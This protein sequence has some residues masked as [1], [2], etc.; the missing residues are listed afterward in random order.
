MISYVGQRFGHYI[1]VEIIDRGGF[2]DVYL[3]RHVYLQTYA[4][5]KVLK[6]HLGR[7][8]R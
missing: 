1:L 7:G 2:A 3:G 8:E 5:V 4:A 6:T